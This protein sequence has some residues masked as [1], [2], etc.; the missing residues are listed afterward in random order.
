MLFN[1]DEVANAIYFSVKR[2]YANIHC[3]RNDKNHSCQFRFG[4]DL[5]L[6]PNWN[7]SENFEFRWYILEFVSEKLKINITVKK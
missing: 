2:Q 7:V 3:I 1:V 4:T 5:T 6:A